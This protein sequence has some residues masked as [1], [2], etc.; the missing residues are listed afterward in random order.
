MTPGN[1]TAPS[2]FR[3]VPR[4]GVIYVMTEAGRLGYRIVFATWDKVTRQP[5]EL[6]RELAATL[7]A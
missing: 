7:A 3:A 2:A 4:T 5:D 1:G 6:L